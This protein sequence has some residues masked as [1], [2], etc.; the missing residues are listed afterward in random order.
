[1]PSLD[2]RVTQL[3]Q[4]M[5]TSKVQPYLFLV[6]DTTEQGRANWEQQHSQPFPKDRPVVLFNIIQTTP[7]GDTPCKPKI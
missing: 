6:G 2:S 4:R 7:G 1:M 3:E 5:T